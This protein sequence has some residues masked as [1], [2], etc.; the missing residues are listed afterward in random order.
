[1]ASI[2]GEKEEEK[3][4]KKGRGKNKLR[5]D[6]CD[7]FAKQTSSWKQKEVYHLGL[8]IKVIG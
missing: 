6:L 7:S 8:Y 1:M 4:K 2:I 3:E 5:E